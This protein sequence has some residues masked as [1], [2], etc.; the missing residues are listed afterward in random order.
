MA[1]TLADITAVA[2][3]G[4]LQARV[5]ACA[6]TRNIADPVDWAVAHRWDI[7]TYDNNAIADS[8]QYA[9]DTKTINVNQA[10]GQR[11]DTILD[12]VIEAAVDAIIAAEQ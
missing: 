12:T 3:D 4:Y 6:A 7:A 5:A 2:N 10:T 1:A 8:Y 11:T 9:E